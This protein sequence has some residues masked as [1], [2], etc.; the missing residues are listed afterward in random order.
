[1]RGGDASHERRDVRCRPT[2]RR[3]SGAR[4]LAVAPAK[5]ALVVAARRLLP[6]RLYDFLRKAGLAAIASGF[7]RQDPAFGPGLPIPGT[8]M[9]LRGLSKADF[10]VARSYFKSGLSE[11]EVRLAQVPNEAA[12]NDPARINFGVFDDGEMVAAANLIIRGYRRAEG[13]VS[14]AAS[15]RRRGLAS[16][17]HDH[18]EGLCRTHGY[19]LLARIDEENAESLCFFATRGYREIG[20]VGR[21]KHFEKLPLT[22]PSPLS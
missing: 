17:M 20:T 2:P 10:P 15:H 21:F 1:M 16:R 18:F 14:V 22:P 12:F 5:P 4:L 19:V 9:V 11:R 13:G 8:T 3:P 7:R 6:A